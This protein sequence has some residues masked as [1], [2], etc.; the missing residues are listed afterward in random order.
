MWN[1]GGKG[2]KESR[3]ARSFVSEAMLESAREIVGEQVI[4]NVCA[5]VLFAEPGE[6]ACEADGPIGG[7]NVRGSAALEDW[8]NNGMTPQLRNTV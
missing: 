5:D 1:D 4:A 3:S 7:R 2:R 6:C 8:N